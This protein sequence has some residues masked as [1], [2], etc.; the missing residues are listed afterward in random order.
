MLADP[1]AEG[2]IAPGDLRRAE[3]DRALRGLEPAGAMPVAIAASLLGAALVVIPAEGIAD[4]RLQRFLE[5]EPRRQLHQL[6][7][8]VR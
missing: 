6:R 3:L 8:A 7:P 5:D 1:R 2:L 4:L